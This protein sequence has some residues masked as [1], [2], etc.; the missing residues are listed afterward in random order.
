MNRPSTDA[1]GGHALIGDGHCA[2]LI[3]RCATIDWLCLPRFDSDTCFASLLGGPEHGHWSVAPV[4]AVTGT[5]RRYLPA[6]AILE[7][8]IE[9][10][11]GSLVITDFMPWRG[12][13]RMLV[14]R[15]RCVRGT[16][17]VRVE[18]LARF[19]YG[20]AIPGCVESGARWKL[21]LGP[22][23]LWLDG[24]TGLARTGD[25][26]LGGV[27]AIA[28]G[29]QRDF[30]LSCTE[31]F[32]APPLVPDAATLFDQ[33]E[34]FWHEWSSQYSG[35]G[36]YAEA[37]RRSLITLRLLTDQPTGGT[38]AAPTS[39]LPEQLGG[40]RNW[41][42]R[43][44]WL[45]DASFTLLAFAECGFHAEA[46]RWREWL[47]RCMA[48]H[49]SQLQI[50]Y[51]LDGSRRLPEW[52]CDWL[53]GYAGSTPVRFGNAAVGQ[54]QADVY[55][56]V[57]KSMHACRRLGLS[58]D[59]QTWE[60][61]RRLVEHLSATWQQPGH[62]IWEMRGE[63]RIFTLSRVM[64]WV[65][66]DSAMH[67]AREF[68]QAA[69]LARWTS[70]AGTI[71]NDVLA[72][73]FHTGR[74]CFTQSYGDAAVDASLLL[75]PLYGF[76]DVADPRMA[77]TIEVIER[78]L[79][80]D[81]LLRRYRT[82]DGRDGLEGGEGS[83]L[84]CNFWLVQVRQLQGRLPQAQA[85]FERLLDLSN[86]LGLLAE[87][88]DAQRGLLCGNFPQAISHVALIHAARALTP[89]PRM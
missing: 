13:Q 86:D 11:S 57:L 70:L 8:T 34:R 1:I 38:I 17:P 43:Y 84:A 79:M 80:H 49:P 78:E 71:R 16:M 74:H 65:A 89:D 29:E 61:E 26:T 6:T 36:R 30:V 32:D 41:D 10:A 83:F 33:T 24:G 63:P 20:R 50:V 23:T 14:R 2:A 81:G 35:E 25:G 21:L 22:C 4:D 15:L 67:S 68:H 73:G 54:R 69:P 87:E 53:P 64:A 77:G 42:Y 75:L 39:S 47:E 28:E 9:T 52:T 62:G 44:A 7:T 27:L 31:S 45:R 58:P 18:L 88:Y 85:L 40:S 19:D 5:A 55:G 46:S 72:H 48:G 82:D 66:V 3:D 76:I 51:R 37:V 56:E 12:G 59:A 60:L